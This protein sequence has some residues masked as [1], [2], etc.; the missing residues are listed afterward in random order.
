MKRILLIAGPTAVFIDSVRV[1]TNISSGR[2]GFLL[3]SRLKDSY[4]IDLLVSCSTC[5]DWPD[6]AKRFF[7]AEE[8]LSLI[9]SLDKSYDLAVNLA[10][11]SDFYVRSIRPGKIPSDRPC[12]IELVPREK[13]WPYLLDISDGLVLFKLEP[14][15]SLAEKEAQQ[16]CSRSGKI[17]FVVAN[18]LKAGSYQGKIVSK[19]YTSDL[20]SG[21][22]EM[23][24]RISREIRNIL[25]GCN[26]TV[27]Y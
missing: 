4:D 17:R 19:T 20:I 8:L 1:I 5:F 16:L 9:K 11:I 10:A 3:Y 12:S 7:T 22:E 18:S 6:E 26:E 27:D 14:S 21:R 13:F 25:G 24:E 2:L 15:L 23:A